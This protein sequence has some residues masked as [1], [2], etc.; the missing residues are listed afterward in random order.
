MEFTMKK[1]LFIIYMA[2]LIFTNIVVVHADNN[3]VIKV[4]Y[5][6]QRGLTEKDK[7][8][9]YVGYTVDYLE[10]IK[11]YTG[12]EYEFVEVDG[13]L[14]QQISTL[15]EMLKDGEID[16][17]GGT[18]YSDELAKIYD[19]PGYPYGMAYTTLA[20]NEGNAEWIS[21]D[22]QNWNGIKVGIYPGLERREKELEKF[23]N[24]NGFSYELV[25]FDEYDELMQAMEDGTVDATLQ[26]DI[27]MH[28]G[29]K[30]IAKFLPVPYYF[31]IS[32]NNSTLIREINSALSNINS[33]NPYLQ[34]S[35]YKKYFSVNNTFSISEENKEYIKSLGII[36]VL[37]LDGNAPI[38]YY[39][40]GAKGI[41]ISYLEK[42]KETTGLQYEI[43]VAKDYEDCLKKL[44]E[45]DID[46]MIGV[47]DNC[48]LLSEI[49]MTLSLPYLKSHQILVSNKK[50]DGKE[51]V[52]KDFIYNTEQV[53]NYLRKNKNETAYLDAYCTSFYLQNKGKYAEIVTDINDVN[54][55]Q[56]SIGLVNKDKMHL[57]SII[58][59]YLNSVTDEQKQEIIYENLV[60]HIDYTLVDFLKVYV[61]QISV[62]GLILVCVG[63]LLYGRS[64]RIKSSMMREIV[65]Q[66]KR[67]N[68]LS[69]LTDEC[70]FEYSYEKD[71]LLIQNDKI[72]F[73]HRHE[74]KHYMTNN[75][76]GFLKDMIEKKEDSSRDFLMEVKNEKRWYRIILKVIKNENGVA[77]YALGKI[78]DVNREVSEHYA[79]IEK[80]KR[81]ALT[82]L[83]N[84]AAA[85]E[86]INI[87]L[88]MDS[89]KGILIMFDVDNFK[90]VNDYLGHPTGD[91]LL[92]E[93]SQFIEQFFREEDIK[94]R[95]GGD[96]FLI[97]VHAS[98]SVD[99]LTEKLEEFILQANKVVFDQYK[100]FQVSISIGAAFA[101]QSVNTYDKLYKKVDA[102]M[103]VA[104]LGGKNGFFISDGT[105]CMRHECI[106]CKRHCKRSEY[107]ASKK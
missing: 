41:S 58:N 11:K 65:L 69:N 18:V 103:Y 55:I 45:N 85:Q 78:C 60:N 73:D 90:S 23:A 74:I 107:L 46:L 26:V 15:L 7:K 93:I 71:Y 38:Q 20:V 99:A 32:K 97:F 39:D 63:A 75:Q 35:L 61:W 29:F 102:A 87:L 72:M 51:D 59:S 4:G 52:N 106:G 12:W 43:I 10:E 48:I 2:F 77:T 96:E 100:E 57:L 30:S 62:V 27:S 34:A 54:A 91:K 47:P 89:S 83:L 19:Y 8:G 94:C 42:I 64:V 80:S 70:L 105:E 21:D 86:S 16:I 33:A 56:Y 36:K 37:M 53:L 14:N 28:K 92:K 95:L 49:D 66:H 84:R 88:E 22:F 13:D 24:L 67:F 6:I 81:D 25:T 50:G 40:Q 82:N 79:L 17:L 68:E 31:A 101:S 3:Q 76:Y 9:N 1:W 98:M 44:K 5:P 104:K